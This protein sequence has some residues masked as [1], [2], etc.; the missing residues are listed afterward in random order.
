MMMMMIIIIITI[1]IIIIHH[2][3]SLRGR[4]RVSYNQVSSLSFT[5]FLLY[6]LCPFVALSM[7]YKQIYTDRLFYVPKI[8]TLFCLVQIK[9]VHIVTSFV[10]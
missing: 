4:T 7:A 10:F 8:F 5:V 2:T 6:K 9:S 3:R 1:I